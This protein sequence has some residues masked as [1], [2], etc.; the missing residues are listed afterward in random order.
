MSWGMNLILILIATGAVAW[1]FRYAGQQLTVNK[2]FYRDMPFAIAFGYVF[3]V[4][5]LV[6]AILYYLQS[7]DNNGVPAAGVVFFRWAVQGFMGFAIAAY[8][9]RLFGRYVGTTGTRKLFRSMP[10][11][12]TFGVL[13]IIIYAVVS[14]F[15]GVIALRSSQSFKK[16]SSS[17][18]TR[19]T[20]SRIIY[21]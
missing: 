15:A 9:F 20:S 1:G 4:V 16:N 2:P 12:A 7:I 18:A 14:I 3:G 5:V 10:L 21:R 17:M 6:G 13:V 8:L 11:T 19:H